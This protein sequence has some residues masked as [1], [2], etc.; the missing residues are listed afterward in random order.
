M[1]ADLSVADDLSDLRVPPAHD[2]SEL[3]YRAEP[4]G[5]I[6]QT[7]GGITWGLSPRCWER[8][9]SRPTRQYQETSPTACSASTRCRSLNP[10][11]ST[12]AWPRAA[13]KHPVPLVA[14]AIPNA[15]SAATGTH[16]RSSRCAWDKAT[17]GRPHASRF[18]P[19]R[20]DR[21]TVAVPRP[22]SAASGSSLAH[23]N[24][25]CR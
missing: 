20:R 16:L 12:A 22:R 8:W 25:N 24:P 10:S 21:A 15:L 9:T 23:A 11:C 4:A 5:V 14:P 18:A 6:G 7:K 2:H 17:R 3:R 13:D 1:V 19:E